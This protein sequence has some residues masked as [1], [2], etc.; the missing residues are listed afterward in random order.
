M[1]DVYADGV[2]ALR[3]WASGVKSISEFPTLDELSDQPVEHTLHAGN[4]GENG[5]VVDRQRVTFTAEEPVGGSIKLQV[6]LWVR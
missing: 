6:A 4:A 5:R 3:K 2:K 1:L